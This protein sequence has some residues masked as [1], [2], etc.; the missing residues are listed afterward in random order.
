MPTRPESPAARA[1]LREAALWASLAE[2]WR[3]ERHRVIWDDLPPV[4]ALVIPEVDPSQDLEKRARRWS[5][6]LGDGDLPD[7]AL[8]AAALAQA[9]GEA[10][11]AED[12]VLATQAYEDRR[13]LAADRVIPW[14]VPWLDA[15][16]NWFPDD[17]ADAEAASVVLLGLGEQHRLAPSLAGTEGLVPP[18]HDGF[19]PLQ[20]PEEFG[21]RL[22]SLWGGI[23]V[24]GRSI[25]SLTGR[26]PVG[27]RV[28]PSDR[29][30][31]DA[32]I[33]WY[34]IAGAH[35]QRLA[36]EYPGTARY[37]L[38]LAGRSISTVQLAADAVWNGPI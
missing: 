16:A 22:G 36:L 23:V 11:A 38:D 12:R 29:K 10:W 35:W 26:V 9:E 21:A 25:T 18:G 34:R 19:G 20:V 15:V 13:F 28:W 24:F 32:V 7:L 1:A 3:P 37:W 33:A 14:A 4:E 27:G 30:I 31:D 8:F 2:Q 17:R 5:Y 6:Q